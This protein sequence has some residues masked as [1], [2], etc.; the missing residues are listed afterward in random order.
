MSN[1][2]VDVFVGEYKAGS[3]FVEAD[4]AQRAILQTQ[5]KG[6]NGYVEFE[7]DEKFYTII[8]DKITHY[9]AVEVGEDFDVTDA[10]F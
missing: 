10:S 7:T 3:F 1:F 5:Q 6:R 2:Q 4:G 9:E 8:A